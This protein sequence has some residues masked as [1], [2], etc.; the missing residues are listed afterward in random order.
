MAG[1]EETGN[2]GNI[3]FSGTVTLEHYDENGKL[4]GF[5]PIPNALSTFYDESGNLMGTCITDSN[6]KISCSNLT[7]NNFYYITVNHEGREFKFKLYM[8]LIDLSIERIQ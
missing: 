3:G 8:S 4:I 5:D 6:G 1:Y 2:G 7:L